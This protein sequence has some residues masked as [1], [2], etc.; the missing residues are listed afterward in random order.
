[1]RSKVVNS[2][3]ISTLLQGLHEE[4]SGEQLVHLN[5]LQGLHEEQ[6]GEQLVHLNLLQGLHEEQSGEQ[7]VHLNP[8]AGLHQ[9]Q[10]RK[11]TNNSVNRPFHKSETP[12]R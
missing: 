10:N 1:M 3:S 8:T 12:N 5:L 9:S 11:H 4:Q 2:L 7:L 6:S